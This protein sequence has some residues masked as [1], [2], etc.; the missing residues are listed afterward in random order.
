M[1]ERAPTTGLVKYR[2]RRTKEVQVL[3][4][5]FFIFLSA[6]YPG[7]LVLDPRGRLGG[8]GRK[9]GSAF[10]EFQDNEGGILG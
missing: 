2:F 9:V 5:R 7:F 10:E 1:S 8:L 4:L 3:V 6:V